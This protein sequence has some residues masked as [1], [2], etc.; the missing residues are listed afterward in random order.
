VSKEIT[1][2]PMASKPLSLFL[3]VFVFFSCLS[4]VGQDS[5]RFLIF[6]AGINYMICEPAEKNYIRADNAIHNGIFAPRI[7]SE[8]RKV[9][10]GAKIEKRTAN[11]RFGFIT[12]IRFTHLYSGVKKIGARESFYVLFRE[13]GTTTEFLRVKELRETYAYLGIPLELRFFPYSRKKF[14]LFLFAGSEWTYRLRAKTNV[15]FFN[16]EMDIHETALREILGTSDSW[17]ATGYIGAGITI[18]KEKPRFS[19]GVT[20]PVFMTHTASIFNDPITGGGF[21]VQ[22]HIPF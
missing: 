8:M 4:A 9:Y 19:V 20:A 5:L 7:V 18:G 12:G 15:V 22:F 1:P 6:E 17:Y 11:N 16:T 13:S 10:V 21:H 3:F 14:G 2:K